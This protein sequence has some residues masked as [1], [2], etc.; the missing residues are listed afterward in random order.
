M[1]RNKCE[2]IESPLWVSSILLKGEN[3]I[4][5]Y[6]LPF[7][8]QFVKHA[9]QGVSNNGIRSLRVEWKSPTRTLLWGVNEFK[10]VIFTFV[11]RFIEI[12]Y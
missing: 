8:V 1:L 7:H 6:F 11:V 3:E 10:F 2:S 12:W 4:F 9:L 5:P